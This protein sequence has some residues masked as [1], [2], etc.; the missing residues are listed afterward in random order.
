MMIAT[1]QRTDTVSAQQA[2][3]VAQ[4]FI[5]DRLTDLMGAGAPWRM[6]SPFGRVWIVPIWIAYPGHD[7]IGVIGSIAVDEWTGNIVS[8]TPE[9]EVRANA[10]HFREQNE[11]A[12]ASG[13]NLLRQSIAAN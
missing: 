8:W 1:A 12:I 13:F 9:D 7:L 2:L 3:E 10:T 4:D 11:A 5:A 6:S